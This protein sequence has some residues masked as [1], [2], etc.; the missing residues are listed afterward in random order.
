MAIVLPGKFIY[1]AN[2]HV[3]SLATAK[4]LDE[5]IEGTYR[6]GPH[7]APVS[8]LSK[9]RVPFGE[10]ELQ[11]SDVI[12]GG[13]I[14]VSTVR[15]PYDWFVSCWIRRRK[16]GQTLEDFLE[17]L[18]G[19]PYVREG[20]ILG[21]R[22][23]ETLRWESLEKNLNGFLSRFDHSVSLPKMNLTPGKKPWETYYSK[24]AWAIANRRFGREIQRLGYS[25]R[26]FSLDS[27]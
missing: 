20:R 18:S 10:F 4:A 26:H 6:V 3:A 25:L 8:E 16:S 2:H 14:T 21:H 23:D 17:N 15:D 11:V 1:L 5:Q 13:E 24:D 12:L 27:R 19:G 22:S 9:V 7:H